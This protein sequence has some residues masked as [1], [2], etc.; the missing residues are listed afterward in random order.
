MAD[1]NINAVTRRVVYSGSAGTGPYAFS[2]EVLVSSDI[3]V[4]FN[5]T[6]LTLTT[7]YTVTINANGTGSVTIVTGTNVPTT[8]DANDTIIIVGARDIERTTDF[9]TAGDLLATSLNE[10]LDGL[11]IFDQQIAEEQKRSLMAPVYDPAHADDGGTL[12]MTL[13]AKADRLGKSLVFN[14][15]TGNPEAGPTST[16]IANAQ[17]NATAAAASAVAAAGS[18]TAAG[19]SETN[20]AASAVTAASYSSPV[21]DLF[22][23]GVDFTAGSSTTITLS[24]SGLSEDAVMITFDG[25][26]QHHDQYSISGTT[27]TFTSAI[28]VG[29]GFV[30]AQY[31]TR[32]VGAIDNVAIG[33][34]TPSTGVFTTING[35]TPATAQYTTAE[36]TKL[37]GIETSATA[38]QTGA[39]IKAAYEAEA[40]TNAYDD[41]AVSK[42]AGIEALAD[43]TD[44][45]NVTAAGALMDSELTDIASIKALNQ[46]VS[47]TDTPTFTGLNTLSDI[48]FEGAT[49]DAFET[50][51]TVVD[52]TADRTVTIP[53]ATTTLVG[54]DVTQTLTNKTLTAPTINGVVGGTA[55]SQTITALTN[56]TINGVAA[57]TAQY[58]TAEETK[59]AGIETAA[60]ADQTDAEIRAAVEAATDS[61]VFTD[62]DHT[63][64]NGIEALA[65]VTDTANVTAAGA[66]MDSELTDIASVKAI[67]QGLTTSGN[68]QFSSVRAE[69]GA[70]ASDIRG[71]VAR[72]TSNTSSIGII[73][74]NSQANVACG[75]RT[76][77]SGRFEII[78]GET[79]GSGL[80]TG[81]IR[82]AFDSDGLKFNGD[83]ASGN[84]LDDYEEGTWTPVIYLGGSAQT[85]TVNENSY[86]KIGNVV[87]I[88]FNVSFSKD[89]AT[90][91]LNVRG[92]PFSSAASGTV[93]VTVGCAAGSIT[94]TEALFANID[95]SNTIVNYAG[96]SGDITQATTAA[97]AVLFGSFSYHTS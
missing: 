65:D 44:A 54:T 70:T 95:G 53:D 77:G 24:G 82:A 46:G 14:A 7:D 88:R 93:A 37:S 50:T 48:I 97:T 81:N 26:V 49:A 34:N 25:V 1:Y 11:T 91:N 83:T 92:L 75:F 10:Q 87:T 78:T 30:E 12:D 86:T 84:A 60:T 8:P 18:E 85:T 90:G 15:T 59:L 22:T 2:F 9:V 45:T 39:E 73:A 3:V 68:P 72:A 13:P 19:V 21:T 41:A 63:K 28:P 23:A 38:D 64:L 31:A 29:V 69:S 33:A 61:N 56:T 32:S 40:D 57:P 58:T 20:A 66:L 36:E 51:L 96:Q 71:L 74:E 4:Y 17:T 55:T 6:S 27:V 5:S 80:S 35:V 76:G 47:T 67:N 42:L 94:S 62:A 43:V 16:D 79:S 89:A 52:P